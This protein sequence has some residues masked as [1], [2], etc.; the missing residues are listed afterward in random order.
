MNLEK[1]YINGEWINP[2]IENN[3]EVINPSSEE[4]C[5]T[6]SLGSSKDTDAAVS[7]GKAKARCFSGWCYCFIKADKSI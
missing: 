3:F 4:I 6:I 7:K 5:A 1:F 2:I